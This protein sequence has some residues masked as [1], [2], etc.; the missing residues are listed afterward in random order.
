MKASNYYFLKKYHYT[1]QSRILDKTNQ[2]YVQTTHQNNDKQ[3]LKE[4]H[5][6]LPALALSALIQALQ[7]DHLD[8]PRPNDSPLQSEENPPVLH[9]DLP[10]ARERL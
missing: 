7:F 4:L 8:G 2:K 6:F 1:N 10:D 5:D 3:K 9:P